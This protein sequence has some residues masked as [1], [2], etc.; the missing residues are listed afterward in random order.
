MHALYELN[1][2]DFAAGLQRSVLAAVKRTTEL[3]AVHE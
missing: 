2:S 3:G 1:N